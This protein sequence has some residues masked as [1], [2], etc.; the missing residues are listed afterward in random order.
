MRREKF[1]FRWVGRCGWKKGAVLYREV[2][3]NESRSMGSGLGVGGCGRGGD[4]R[5]G[6][7]WRS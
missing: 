2:D 5:G 1:L 4:G 7:G 3:W 6:V